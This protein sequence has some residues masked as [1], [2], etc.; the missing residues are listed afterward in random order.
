MAVYL[1]NATFIDWKTLE[2][3]KGATIKVEEGVSGAISF[4][5]TVPA[6]GSDTV[7]DCG[8][9]YVTKSFVCG[10]HHVYSA[11]S[12]GMN[13]VKKAPTNFL[14]VLQYIWW[15]LD[16]CLDDASVEASALVT[17]AACAKNGVTFCIDHHASPFAIPGSLEIIAKAF[18]KVGVGHLLC[19]E[20]TDRDGLDKAQ[21][22]LDETAS[23]LAS[24]RQGLVGLHAG[25][26]VG[27]STL[28]KAVD[29][30]KQTKSGIHVHVA[31]GTLDQED[32]QEKYG[33]RVIERYQK[34]GVLDFSKT[35]LGHCLHLDAKE[36]AILKDSPVWL[37]QNAESNMNNNV[38]AFDW[39]GLGPNMMLGTDGMHSDMLRSAKVGFFKNQEK[40]GMSY[41]E[42]Y[43]RFRNASQY[44]SSNGFTGDGENNLVVLDYDPPTDFGQYNLVGHILFGIDSTHVES[45][46]SQ[47]RLI[48][49]N[50][51]L[52]MTD[53]AEINAFARKQADKVWDRMRKA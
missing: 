26:T 30:A 53:E 33:M 8:G 7:L 51:K 3:T 38:G 15:A 50:R 28:K 23:Y 31:E 36:R 41:D 44:L 5:D 29:L 9:K 46:I 24:G 34:A 6:G 45:V 4:V 12:R 48:V 40:G 37:V 32:S 16:K 42:F 49:K 11:L 2:F 39:T 25:F 47:G 18:D 20:V 35:I 43:R 21:A 1:A 52:T 17:A 19:Y 13:T 27:E 22:G 14:E 10:H